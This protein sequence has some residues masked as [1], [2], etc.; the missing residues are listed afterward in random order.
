MRKRTLYSE[1]DDAGLRRALKRGETFK[2]IAARLGRSTGSV[3]KHWQKI[4]GHPGY[5]AMLE[6]RR[7]KTK[8]AANLGKRFCLNCTVGFKP[9]HRTNFL[10]PAC[11]KIATEA[12]M[13]V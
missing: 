11:G 3:Q 12:M 6:E 2:K 8:P 5:A 7:T 10:C 4:T 9:T 13:P 1:K